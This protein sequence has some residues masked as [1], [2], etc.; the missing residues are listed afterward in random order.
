MDSEPPCSTAS[1]VLLYSSDTG[2]FNFIPSSCLPC[3]FCFFWLS[4]R[5]SCTCMVKYAYD[6]SSGLIISCVSIFVFFLT[7]HNTTLETQQAKAI[8]HT[9][10]F[11]LFSNTVQ[12]FHTN[13]FLVSRSAFKTYL[14]LKS[15]LPWVCDTCQN[16]Y[17]SAS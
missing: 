8:I 6:T 2:P 4:N 5:F 13:R 15:N 3:F 17:G 11:G 10:L 7:Q 1:C 16:K 14:I 12:Y 9:S